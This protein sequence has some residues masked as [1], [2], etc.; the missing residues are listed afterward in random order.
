MQVTKYNGAATS[1]AIFFIEKSNALKICCFI[2]SQHV[3]ISWLLFD[4]CEI[5]DYLIVLK[6]ECCK[7]ETVVTRGPP[8]IHI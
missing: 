5:C 2:S 6:V 7:P 4:V 8:G 3:T 1:D